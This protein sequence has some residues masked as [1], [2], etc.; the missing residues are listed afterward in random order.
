MLKV[1]LSGDPLLSVQFACWIFRESSVF[2]SL[3]LDVA[4]K[5]PFLT[6]ENRCLYNRIISYLNESK[7][8]IRN[9]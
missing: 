2:V 8:C 6:P 4:Q 1:S 9:H 3:N 7:E 5:R